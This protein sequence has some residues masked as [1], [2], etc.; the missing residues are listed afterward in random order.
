MD[1][2]AHKVGPTSPGH[3]KRPAVAILRN[4]LE[5]KATLLQGIGKALLGR[6]SITVDT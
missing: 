6:L 5:T 4:T 3:H 1:L 2:P